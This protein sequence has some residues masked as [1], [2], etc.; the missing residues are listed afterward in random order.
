ML[1][2]RVEK[3]LRHIAMVA[4]FL[5]DKN[6]KHHFK[7]EF[8]LFHRSYSI[9]FCLICEMLA[10]FSVVEMIRKYLVSLEKENFCVMFMYSK[11]WAHKIRKFHAAVSVQ[12]CNN[13]KKCTK[14]CDAGAKLLV[15]QP[16]PIASLPFLLPLLGIVA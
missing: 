13:G 6:R 7:R 14:K 3:L 16:N 1:T 9:L 11:K 12:S 10:T 5:D 15:C 8:A 2:N 4:K